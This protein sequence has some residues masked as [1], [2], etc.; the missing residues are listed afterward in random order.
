MSG[1]GVGFGVFAY[2]TNADNY[3]QTFQPNFMYNTHV[4]GADAN[5]DD[6]ADS[7]QY[8]PIKYWP[9]E[10]GSNA[11]YGAASDDVDKVSFFAYAPF[12]SVNPASGK[13]KDGHAST[14]TEDNGN[15]TF[16]I[17]GMKS[18][19]ATG[20]P[21][22]KY[23]A[24][25]Y[26]DQQVD[27]TWGTV[28]SAQVWNLKN[29]NTALTPI[30]EAGKPWT[31]IQHPKETSSDW[32][33]AAKV[34]FNF[35]HGLASLNVTVDTYADK[36][37][38]D[39]HEDA[40]TDP[41]TTTK[42]FIRSVTFEGFDTKG[43]L[44]LNNVEDSKALWY[45]FDCLN[46][47]NNGNEVTIKDGRKDGKEGVTAATKEYAA[48]NPK[49][50][51]GVWTDNTNHP[52]VT[53]DPLNLFATYVDGVDFGTP[54]ADAPIYVIPNGDKLKVTIEYDV[55]T[56]DS[57]LAGKLNDGVTSGSVVKNVITRYITQSEIGSV[58]AAGG[59]ITLQNGKQY[60][61]KLH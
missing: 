3:D 45:N 2:Y 27:L 12:V 5:T 8:S 32:N 23:I 26:T 40:G 29:T 16:G 44:N 6:T 13:V 15:I 57:K 4:Y 35:L 11:S 41:N 42:V 25:F 7:W 24:S 10:F 43:A 49:F 61:I 17:V 14:Y 54:A 37:T 20:D 28:P 51:Q 22:V 39:P 48:I 53:H 59:D 19:S 47:L 1:T 9:N 38:G 58:G 21:M 33:A 31:N 30:L 52:G 36:A 50:V 46:E 60:T 55:L 56:E 34:K 18:N